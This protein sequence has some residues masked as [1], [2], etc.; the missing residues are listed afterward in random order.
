MVIVELRG[1]R[2]FHQIITKPD[3]CNGI[4]IREY[5]CLCNVCIK[6]RV[7]SCQAAESNQYFRHNID[8]LKAKWYQFHQNDSD[9]GNDNE[10]L[11]EID[12]FI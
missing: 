2:K 12:M 10:E 7:E 3:K 1:I 4:F 9:K 5:A 6:G 8:V 11:D